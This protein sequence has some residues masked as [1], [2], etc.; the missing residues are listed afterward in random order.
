VSSK[1]KILEMTK[2]YNSSQFQDVLN[3]LEPILWKE[4]YLKDVLNEHLEK[5]KN[6]EIKKKGTQND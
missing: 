6:K 4:P 1:E 5:L 2:G 3:N